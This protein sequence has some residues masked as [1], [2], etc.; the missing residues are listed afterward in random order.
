MLLLIR[1][2]MINFLFLIPDLIRKVFSSVSII[3]NELILKS[4]IRNQLVLF[5]LFLCNFSV[6]Q[7]ISPNPPSI[8]WNYIDTDTLRVVFPKGMEKH[9]FRVA[10][11]ILYI[12]RNHDSLI[13]MKS[14]KLTLLLQNQTVI[15]NGYVALAPFRSEFYTTPMQQSNELGSLNWLD[16]LSMHEY[17]HALQFSNTKVGVTK[18]AYWLFGEQGWNLTSN[19]IVPDWFWEGDAVLTETALSRQ[20]R[21]RIPFF[22]YDFK[23]LAVSDKFYR[24]AKVRN[25]SFNDYIPDHYAFGYL[26]CRYG[27]DNFGPLFWRNVLKA[28]SKGKGLFYPFSKA[29]KKYSGLGV[30]KFYKTAFT[31]LYNDWR[32]DSV[33]ID[34]TPATNVSQSTRFFTSYSYPQ[35]TKEN[36]VI[37]LKSGYNINPWFVLKNT[38][39]GDEQKVIMPGLME[40]GYFTY[41]NGKIAYSQLQYDIRY[42]NRNY[43]NVTIIDIDKR[44]STVITT[45]SKYFSPFLSRTADTVLVV[46]QSPEMQTALVLLNATDG[47]VIKK[48]PNNSGYYYCYPKL[49]VNGKFVF[50]LVRNSSGEMG[51]IKQ[52]LNSNEQ[53]VILPF[54]NNILSGPFL[55]KD[56][57][58][59]FQAS[60][61]GRDNIYVL[62]LNDKSL[63]KVTNRILGCYMPA[64]SLGSERLLFTEF[65]SKGRQLREMDINTD[66]FESV[67][68]K[69]LEDVSFLNTPATLQEDGNILAKIPQ[70]KFSVKPYPLHKS[71]IHI[72]SWSLKFTQKNY[73]LTFLSDN[74]FGS[75]NAEAGAY[76][77]LNE[78]NWF[79]KATLN[80]SVF[81][82]VLFTE[83]EKTPNRNTSILNSGYVFAPVSWDETSV[84][85][86]FRIPLNL[87]KGFFS[88]GLE[89]R[90][91]HK[92]IRNLFYNIGFLNQ[93]IHAVGTQLTFSNVFR[94]PYRTPLSRFGQYIQLTYIKSLNDVR[95]SQLY[96][97]TEFT[98]PAL[99]SNHTA[100]LQV[101]YISQAFGAQ[102]RFRDEFV[103]P[104][105]MILNAYNKF[106]RIGFNYHMPLIYPE[107]GMAGVFYI[108]RMR[109]NPYLDIGLVNNYA[110]ANFSAYRT[111][112]AEFIFDLKLFN[113]LPFEA[114]IRYNFLLN[115]DINK[116]DSFT[117]VQI[118]IP[119]FNF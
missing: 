110:S 38:E 61:Y 41:S 16:L 101:N 89:F 107:F 75:V 85:S 2:E 100:L 36:T 115:G 55:D 62:N 66:M 71:A 59:Y 74:Y 67:V 64:V 32:K 56:Q 6:A 90:V 65:T 17:R 83:L 116:L 54:S 19:L 108:L 105:G 23:T 78:K 18:L 84:N 68:V 48:L 118:F 114:G 98:F 113:V 73:G 104:R 7:E 28:S 76:Y 5:F 10:S 80:Y 92:Y 43:L 35:Y 91:Y 99:F 63:N 79:Y 60:F 26:M 70:R 49:S 52:D 11:N 82:P 95:A 15:S 111:V 102:Y 86:G 47:T 93:T 22:L 39:S 40:D 112:G 57:R 33:L 51:I 96:A 58:L 1:N 46:E 87:T 25:G 45:R 31:E 14:K 24:Y 77:N 72:H 21:G 27:R 88:R 109:F 94:K 34:E 13:G 117:P 12:N 53:T 20:G 37:T 8:K 106:A 81:F 42:A 9:A 29:M 30:N 3:R 119:V 103:Y 44:K 50:S 97:N 69:G 4:G